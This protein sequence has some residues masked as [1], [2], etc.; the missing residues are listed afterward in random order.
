MIITTVLF[1]AG[2]LV[3]NIPSA[4]N[5]ILVKATVIENDTVPFIQLPEVIIDGNR[6]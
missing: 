6:K 1:L 3:G 4:N 5:S 2:N